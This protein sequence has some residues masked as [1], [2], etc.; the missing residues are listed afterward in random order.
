[1]NILKRIPSLAARLIPCHPGAIRRV[2]ISYLLSPISYLLSAV[3]ALCAATALAEDA[4][5]GFAI[6]TYD[7]DNPS[8][9]AASAVVRVRPEEI[10]GG[11][12]IPCA[13]YY[14][15]ATENSTS[16]LLLGITTD[17]PAIQFPAYYYPEEDY[18]ST[19]RSYTLHGV[20]YSTRGYISFAG[21]PYEEGGF[22]QMMHAPTQA[23]ART[24]NAYIGCAWIAHYLEK[25]HYRWAGEKSDSYPLFVFDVVLA[26]DIAPG[27]YKVKFCH[28]NTDATG[29]Y[30]LPSPRV[31]SG[32]RA[33]TVKGGDLTLS[34][35]T[36]VVGG[37]LPGDANLDGKVDLSDAILIRQ[38][39]DN[40]GKYGADGTDGNRITA[41]GLANADVDGVAGVDG[42]DALRIRR[43]LLGLDDPLVVS[44]GGS[45]G[46]EGGGSGDGVGLPRVTK[47]GDA[48]CDGIP[49][50]ADV[51]IAMRALAIPD[52]NGL[53]GTSSGAITLTG[54]VNAD[55]DAIPGLTVGDALRLVDYLQDRIYSLYPRP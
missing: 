55:T 12:L 24:D 42:N 53:G 36:I 27:A 39:A 29:H 40:P 20:N 7:I 2:N 28:Y 45:G 21:Q 10:G 48:N 14:S 6:K 9:D 5:K 25:G 41:L 54:L 32:A 35:L 18:T 38:A 13:V 26:G 34:E 15:E 33:Y 8:A 51:I 30:D 47:F 3:A 46:G 49:N 52:R 43:W 31:E 37:A 44:G 4:T 1:M 23:V 50:I 22:Y 17:S 11:L 19:N 16:G